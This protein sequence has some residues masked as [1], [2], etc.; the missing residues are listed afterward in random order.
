MTC[1]EAEPFLMTYL[2][3]ELVD[4]DR[5]IVEEHLAACSSCRERVAFEA[6]FKST[7]KT[8]VRRPSAPA[9]LRADISRSLDRADGER[10]RSLFRRKALPVGMPLAAAAAVAVF[11][12]SSLESSEA[13]SPIVEDAVRAHEKQLPVEVG[14]GED[15]VKVWMQ[16]KVAVPVR[17]PRLRGRN[18]AFVGGR[19]GHLR[20]RDAAQLLYKVDG[21][22]MTVYVF[23]AEG[24]RLEGSRPR[25]VGR[26][27]VYVDGQRGYNVVYYRD[28][29]V[30][31]AF[32]SDLDQESMIRLVSTAFE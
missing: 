18:A 14:G 24:M 3:R 31:Y 30:G 4:E 17:P 6:S 13:S 8:R 2:D 9:S 1:A 7:L 10:A 16:G 12:G 22:P 11:L 23:D 29:G 25:T 21:S 19:I 27:Q 20:N 26:R 15:Q 28:N 5:L 32:T